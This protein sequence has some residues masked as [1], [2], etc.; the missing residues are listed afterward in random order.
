MPSRDIRDERN[1]EAAV[2]QPQNL[3]NQNPLL[4]QL[5]PEQ[6]EELVEIIMED[7]RNANEARSQ[8]SWGTDINGKGIDFDTKY[9]NL[10]AL[11]EGD[12]VKRPEQWMCGRSLKIAQSIV[13]MLVARLFPAIWN[14]D[15]IKWKP[16]EFTDKKRTKDVNE[17][18]RWVFITWM[19]IRPKMLELVRA[20]I[21]LGTVFTEPYWSVKK[22]DLGDM[23][24]QDVVD[25][26]GAP[27][28]DPATGQPLTIEMK[29][30]NVDEKPAVRN[31]PLT[32]VLTQPGCTDIQDEP[33]ITLKDFYYHELAQEQTEGIVVNV[34]EKL[35]GAV[36]KTII[37]K[38]GSELEKAEKISSLNAKRRNHLVETLTWYGPYDANGDG[39]PE[40]IVVRVAI[41]DE[42]YL[43]GFPVSAIS[44]RGKRPIVQTNFINRM[45]KLLGIGALEQVKPLAEEIDAC[46]RQLQDANT[47]GIMKWGFYDPN[48]DY[49]PDEH[50]AKPR[51]MYP[52]TNP[53]Q[54][55]YFPDM[56]VPIERLIMAIRL[57]MEFIE[58]LT[59]ASSYAMGKES[60]IVGGSGTATR[61]NTIMESANAR[62]NLPGMNMR[63]GIA[64][65]LTQIFDICHLNMPDGLEKRILGEDNEPVFDTN[66]EIKAALMT[67]MDSYLEPN[68]AF[69]DTGTMRELAMVLYDKFVMGG[70]PLVVG[71]VDKLYHATANVFKSFGENPKEWIGPAPVTKETNDPIEEQTIIREGRVISPDPQENHLE[72]ILVHSEALQ[73]PDIVLWSKEAVQV[74]AQHIEEHKNMMQL[75]MQFQSQGKQGGTENGNTGGSAASKAK[76]SATSGEQSLQ[77]NANPA[78]DASANQTA[79]AAGGAPA[80]R[81]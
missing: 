69:G 59:A 57:V 34:D 4:L 68:A 27:Q 55:V 10:I 66:D 71:A 28:L 21:S 2:E 75:L 74:L 63:D 47:L 35:K 73:Q 41:K 44:R 62:F 39:F 58:R 64:E 36:D 56:S 5:S 32:K 16:V 31:I 79:G 29:M 80:V 43:Q 76:P 37:T 40:E 6:E 13:E 19:K 26:N 9:A 54:N 42:I 70:N 15:T 24:E 14:E 51:A 78:Q 33:V 23:Q 50:V 25:E 52:V 38:F 81:Y 67:E 20:G 48:S 46:F 49:N 18:M 45:F 61:T 17:I 1:Q 12:D 7:Y 65:V 11:Y 60:E 53:S 77:G 8:T 30:L 22:R 3:V 72:H